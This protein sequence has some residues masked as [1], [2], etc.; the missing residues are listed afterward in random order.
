MRLASLPGRGRDGRLV[1][2][3]RDLRRCTP[4]AAVAD[5]LQQALERW[6]RASVVLERLAEQ[7]ESDEAPEATSFAIERCLAPLPRAYQFLDGSAYLSHENLVR[8]VRGSDQ[9]P[10]GF[11]DTPLMYQGV[12]DHFLAPTASI[13]LDDPAQGVD[14]ESELAVIVDDVPQG[15]DRDGALEHIKLVVLLNDVSLRNVMVDEL[16][17]GFG[18][19]LSKPHSSLSPLAVSPNSLG[20]AWQNGKLHGRLVS[21]LNGTVIGQPDPAQDMRFDFADLIAYAARTRPL[22]A[23]TLVGGGIVENA[24]PAAGF[25]SL[26]RKRKAEIRLTGAA[27]TPFLAAGDHLEIEFFDADG[28]S[29]FGRI[30]QRV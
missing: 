10:A 5:T 14:F 4:A 22:A 8:S 9:L 13:Q 23:G 18:F 20:N 24:D 21:R 27:T 2:V 19:V 26:E 17:R 25:S 30:D 12:S 15:I 11:Y 29:P 16:A 3:S 7:L 1:V 28:Q 6:D